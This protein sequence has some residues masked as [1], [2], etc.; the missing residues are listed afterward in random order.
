LDSAID[1]CMLEINLD[2]TVERRFET[3]SSSSETPRSTPWSSHVGFSFFS[4]C[5]VEMLVETDKCSS[6]FQY[7]DDSLFTESQ[8][9]IEKSKRTEKIERR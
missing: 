2:R 9:N 4:E 1:S 3:S 7:S 8:K 6:A 5:K